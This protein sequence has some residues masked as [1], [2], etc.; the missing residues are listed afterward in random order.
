MVERVFPD[1]SWDLLFILSF[2]F[3]VIAAIHVNHMLLAGDWSFWTD[4][5]DRQ[6]WPLIAP[7]TAIIV[8]GALQYIAWS[9][10]CLPIGATVGIVSLLVGEWM[11]R[12]F[13][14]HGWDYYPLNFV[15]PETFLPAA[16]L[17][18]IVL[19]WTRSYVVTSV[20]GGLMWGLLFLPMNWPIWVPFMQPV[21][22]NGTLLTVA[23]L[24]GMMYIRAQ[25]PEYLRIIEQGHLRAFLQEISYVVAFTAGMASVF[26]YW[27]PG[28]I[29]GRFVAVWPARVFLRQT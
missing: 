27:V 22:Y 5:K 23:D 2:F 26:F 20:I 4:W 9:Q 17:L 10:T 6:W 7:M 8:C 13:Q 19:M 1:R 14:F 15:W 25:T 11:T 29:V 16:V 3:L 28:Q 21:L 12:F 24:Q 18:D